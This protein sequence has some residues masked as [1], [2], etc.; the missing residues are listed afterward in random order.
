[1]DRK[2]FIRIAGLGSIPLFFN[3]CF[4]QQNQTAYS[5]QIDSNR[6]SGHLTR[7][8][9]LSY[10][11]S[12]EYYDTIVIGAGISGIAAYS[13]LKGTN[14]A[15]FDMNTF[16]GGTAGGGNFNSARF[17]RGAHYDIIYPS[18]YGKETLD[19]LKASNI[20]VFDE[21]NNSYHYKDSEF[22]IDSENESTCLRFGK[23]VLDP[24][25][26]LKELPVFMRLLE[27]FKGKMVMPT[28][29]IDE[30]FDYLN[31]ITFKAW[32][33]DQSE[34][35]DLFYAA[36]DYQMRDDWGAPSSEVSALAGIHYYMCRTY[37]NDLELISP[38]EGNQ[39]FVEKMLA[40]TNYSSIHLQHLCHSI[41]KEGNQF[42]A[43]IIDLENKTVKQVACDKLIYSG[44][45]HALKYIFPEANRAGLIPKYS[46][47][48]SLNL[49]FEKFKSRT[50]FWQN[51]MIT[52]D[53]TFLGFSDSRAQFDFVEEFDVLTAYYCF[54]P[55]QRGLLVEIEGDP[56]RIIE[57]T[58][59][60]IE[61]SFGYEVK[62]KLKMVNLNLMGHAMPVPEVNYLKQDWN[63]DRKFENFVYAG[64]DTGN[65]PLFFEAVSSGLK[66]VDALNL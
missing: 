48:I 3:G 43:E 25:S 1:M 62:S 24:L 52:E 41:K 28:K 51:D 10:P 63:D 61:E 5:V 13:K 55:E 58:I 15:L 17:A 11:V 32:L 9:L 31:Q 47:W 20:I 60:Y 37:E 46:A 21:L 16:L 44:N 54:S 56:Q 27:P 65:L 45:K 12:K 8:A 23:R 64:C 30:K 50:G 29:Q 49:V 36:L 33:N 19:F 53:G 57:K 6:A 40:N 38:P 22:L 66:A 42:I 35:S 7:E 14:A 59:A 26:E 34:F 39:Y 2:T 4:V 18:N